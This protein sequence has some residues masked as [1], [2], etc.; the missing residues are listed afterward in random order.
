LFASFTGTFLA[1]PDGFPIP[2]S[3]DCRNAYDDLD[4]CAKPDTDRQAG[5]NINVDEYSN[6]VPLSDAF[7]NHSFR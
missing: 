6:A 3:N 4:T 1:H 2:S 5:S 7:A